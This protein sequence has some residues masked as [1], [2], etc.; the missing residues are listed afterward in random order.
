MGASMSTPFPIFAVVRLPDPTSFLQRLFATLAHHGVGIADLELDH[1]CY[2]VADHEAYLRWRM[3]LSQQG[4]LLGEHLIG[5]RPISTFRMHAPFVF[6]DRTIHV[7]ELPAPKP[8]SP[9][10][11]G[12]EHAEFVVHEDLDEFAQQHPR[13]SWDRSGLEKPHNPELRFTHAGI[14]AKFHRKALAELIAT[15]PRNPDGQNS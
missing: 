4:R 9:Y 8:G 15:E 13:V 6:Q 12:W 1:L 2:R 7:I 10:P 14:S 3:H 5:G 11:E